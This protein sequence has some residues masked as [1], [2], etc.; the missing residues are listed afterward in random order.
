MKT[1]V[2]ESDFRDAFRAYGRND[3]FSYEG[4]GAL[5]DGLLEFED[6][7]G[8]EIE[9]DVIA[10]CCEYYE[11]TWQEIA[12]DY[13]I[14]LSD[15]DDEDAVADDVR[16]YLSFHTTIVGEVPGGCVYMAF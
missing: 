16:D 4:L 14:D 10:L 13:S 3:Q 11:A 1:T 2:T 9:L 8:S 6:A 12:D 5:Y 15:P 7:T